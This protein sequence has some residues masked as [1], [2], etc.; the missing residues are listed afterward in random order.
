MEVEVSKIDASSRKRSDLQDINAMA[1]SLARYGLMQRLVVT[2]K[3][4]GTYLLVAGG[5]RLA[6]AKQLGWSTISAELR[7]NVTPAE[8][9]ELELEE[10]LQRANMRWYEEAACLLEIFEL[11]TKEYA[12]RG[13]K[14]GYQESS[15][16]LKRSVGSIHNAV[17]VAQEYCK[18]PDMFAGCESIQDALK[19]LQKRKLDQ[20]LAEQ[21]RRVQEK[22]KVNK[23][24]VEVQDVRKLEAVVAPRQAVRPM[25]VPGLS[26]P[27]LEDEDEDVALPALDGFDGVDGPVEVTDDKFE[28][29]LSKQIVKADCLEYVRT[30][31]D[32]FFDHVV[33]DPP[34]AIDMDNLSQSNTGM[35]DIAS[36]ESNHQVEDNKELL[37]ALMPE[38]F[39][40]TRNNSFVCLWYDL[41]QHEFLSSLGRAAGFAVQRWPIVWDKTH[42]CLNQMAEYNFTKRTEV[43]MI[44]RKPGAKLAKVQPTNVIR[45]G[46]DEV[47]KEYNHPF[48][49]PRAAWDFLYQAVALPGQR[50]W[51]PFAGIGSSL[52]AAIE[53]NLVPYCTEEK[54]FYNTL[55]VRATELYGQKYGSR[56]I[57]T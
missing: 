18:S 15:V 50:V 28:V 24:S 47:K 46:N 48:A 45:A 14:F 37:R 11:K 2:N 44:L 6:A 25:G 7:E 20:A 13:E 56:C 26:T 8:L 40:V 21:A 36:V 5:R 22:L 32:G 54:D 4:D 23:K 3:P 10:N 19:V 42:A 51:D 52:Q 9:R 31:P 16:V 27:S 55:L 29:E 41:D 38:L 39:R 30:L 35:D 43:C 17:L 57:F 49:K 33:T 1:E 12:L 34:Y 53:R